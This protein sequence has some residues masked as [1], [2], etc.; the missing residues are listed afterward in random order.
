MSNVPANQPV[1]Y[2][3]YLMAVI[4]SCNLPQTFIDAKLPRIR[5]AYKVG[6]PIAM[7]VDELKLRHQ[8]ERPATKTPRQLAARVV[9]ARCRHNAP[10]HDGARPCQKCLMESH[11]A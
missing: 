7:L 9:Q 10:Q 2:G 11:Y 8:F 3:T 4:N 1:S 5:L 6:E